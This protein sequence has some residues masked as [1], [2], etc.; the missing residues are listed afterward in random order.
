MRDWSYEPISIL[1]LIYKIFRRSLNLLCGPWSIYS[2]GASRNWHTTSTH[3]NMLVMFARRLTQTRYRSGRTL[4]LPPPSKIASS[5]LRDQIPGSSL[6][7]LSSM[8]SSSIILRD[9]FDLSELSMWNLITTSLTFRKSIHDC[10]EE[11]VFHS[12]HEPTYVTLYWVSNRRV[13]RQSTI[14]NNSYS[15]WVFDVSG[16]A[17]S[18]DEFDCTICFEN[19]SEDARCSFH[20]WKI[21]VN[22]ADFKCS[23]ISSS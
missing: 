20:E 13:S 14:F 17:T 9:D 8:T 22:S 19:E 16:S 2:K 4:T 21:D 1:L 7:S 18:I 12:S 15:S 3:T 5:W 23:D 10:H 6:S 11:F